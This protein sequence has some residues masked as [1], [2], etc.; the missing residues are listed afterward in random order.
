MNDY[1]P[2]QE[3]CEY[4]NHSG[5]VFAVLTQKRKRMESQECQITV[6]RNRDKDRSICVVLATK[7]LY[8]KNRKKVISTIHRVIIVS[9]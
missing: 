6:R 2:L 8:K 9:L 4:C 5:W 3:Y 1:C 7:V